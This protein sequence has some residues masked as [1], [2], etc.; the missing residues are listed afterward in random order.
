[1]LSQVSLH[2]QYC[3]F[4]QDV[5]LEMWNVSWSK[6]FFYQGMSCI[7]LLITWYRHVKGLVGELDFSFHAV[8][9]MESRIAESRMTSR[10]PSR[11]TSPARNASKLS[12]H[13][14]QAADRRKLEWACDWIET[15]L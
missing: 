6:L 13:E 9:T 5:L 7:G 1:L 2:L 11:A 10:A 12:L 15:L 8:S 3:K 14:T 4:P